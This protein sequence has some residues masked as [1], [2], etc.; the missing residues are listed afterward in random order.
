MPP[1][2][3]PIVIIKGITSLQ[4]QQALRKDGV[5]GIGVSS[6][7]G[8]ITLSSKKLDTLQSA[9]NVLVDNF[10]GKITSIKRKGFIKPIDF[11]PVNPETF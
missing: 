1:T 11:S 5:T 3:R 4:A 7:S 10:G 9:V 2:N 6:S 8:T